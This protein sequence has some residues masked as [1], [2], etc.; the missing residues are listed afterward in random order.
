VNTNLMMVDGDGQGQSNDAA[1]GLPSG[2]ETVNAPAGSDASAILALA[3]P[4]QSTAADASP[5]D[6]E[7]QLP[8][9]ILAA[10]GAGSSGSGNSSTAPSYLPLILAA[11]ALWLVMR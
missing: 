10:G 7:F 11:A 1:Q 2:V 4:I 8:P 5:V 3:V 6:L 9:G